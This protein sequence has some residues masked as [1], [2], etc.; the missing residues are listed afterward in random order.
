ME[1][2]QKTETKLPKNW[3][4]ILAKKLR[5]DPQFLD[6]LGLS[7]EARKY[8]EARLKLY[9]I[10]HSPEIIKARTELQKVLESIS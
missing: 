6:K 7:P 9:Q 5:E 4:A 10:I 8:I 1:E 3:V 2:K